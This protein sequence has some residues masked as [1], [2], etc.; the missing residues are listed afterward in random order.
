MQKRTAVAVL[1][2]LPLLL[3]ACSGDDDGDDGDTGTDDSASETL[4]PD[5]A[6]VKDA[7][8]AAFFDDSCDLLTEDYLVDKA[9]LAET[10]EEACE[11]YQRYWVEPAYDEDDVIVTEIEV[12][13][14]VATAVVGSEYINI[15]TKY[16]LMKVDGSW[17]I[18]C[19]DFTC[20]HL[21]EPEE[22]S[23]EVS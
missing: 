13:G 2:A 8:V 7:L 15:T 3:T 21:D 4:S 1:L 22:P 19:E 6:A 20:D 9:L 18:S 16:E 14:D 12:D 11:E 10:P 5:E 17:L 23:A